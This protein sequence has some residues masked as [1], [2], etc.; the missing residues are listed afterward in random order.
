MENYEIQKPETDTPNLESENNSINPN[1]LIK[2]IQSKKYQLK[3]GEEVYY[4]LLDIY[5]DNNIYFKLRKANSLSL[6]Q[7]TNKLNYNNITELFL[8]QKEFY[9]DLTKVLVFFDSYLINGK[10]KLENIKQKNLMLLKLYKIIDFNQIECKLE[11]YKNKI[12]NDEMFGLLIE[13]I[14]EIKNDKK[15]NNENNIINELI[16]I[17]KENENRIKKLEDKIKLL[18]DVIKE[19]KKIDNKE[20]KEKNE[21]LFEYKNLENNKSQLKID[22]NIKGERSDIIIFPHEKPLSTIEQIKEQISNQ[23][24]YETLIYLID[25]KVI[26][27]NEKDGLFSLKL[28]YND[29]NKVPD[30]SRFV[31]LGQSVLLTGGMSKDMK[32]LLKCYLIGIIENDSSE[33]PK[34]SIN[35][36]PYGDFKIGRERHNLIYLPNKNYV[37]A[38]G[39]FLS[40]YCECSDIY[41]GNWE[42]MP[43]MNKSRGNASMAYINNRYIYIMGGFELSYDSPKGNYLN[44]IEYFDINN[45]GNGWTNI[46]FSNPYGYNLS[47]TAL[48]V[49]PITKNIFLICGGFDGKEYKNTVYKIDCS[50]IQNP[51][52]E[53]SN[54]LTTRTIF[55]HN[56]FCKINKGYYNYDFE[57]QIYVFDY[58]NWRFGIKYMN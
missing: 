39:G 37:V 17:N 28:E 22:N 16:N 56:M 32:P 23:F 1:P 36:S 11:L 26:C 6:F 9:K 51:L 49:V 4:L 10:I 41:K 21:N 33:R 54:F 52:V 44:D 8:L 12:S 38:C 30:K 35:I 27:Y 31:N 18:E 47:L 19:N 34:Y 24:N 46:N 14:N 25:D 43:S 58:E 20:V 5:S 55:T 29:L 40:K 48:G 2:L 15:Q 3:H 45:F 7:Y 13:E 42:T 53:E 57:G 50:D